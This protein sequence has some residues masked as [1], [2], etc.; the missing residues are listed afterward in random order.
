MTTV[1]DPHGVKWFSKNAIE[2]LCKR[3]FERGDQFPLC[4]YPQVSNGQEGCGEHHETEDQFFTRIS[5][6]NKDYLPMLQALEFLP[7][8]PTLFNMGT[9]SGG[10]LS[11]CFKFDIDD[12]MFDSPSGIMPTAM[13]AAKVLKSGGGVG[14]VFSNLRPKGAVVNSTHGQA[15]GAEGVARILHVLAKEITQGGKRDAAQMGIIHCNH[16][17]A[18]DFIHW[19]DNDPDA[20]GTFNISVALTDEFMTEAVA[21][22]NDPDGKMGPQGQFLTEMAHSAW[23]TGDPGCYFIDTAERGNPTP[24]AGLLTGSN[25]CGEVPLLNN[26][27]CNLGSINLG[28]FYQ[29]YITDGKIDVHQ[30][31]NWKRLEQVARVATRYLDD[32][33][34]RNT[35]PDPDIH[36]AAI[37]TR[38][39]GL[40]VCGFADLLALMNIDY[41]SDEAVELGE[42]IMYFIN[43]HSKMESIALAQEKGPAPCFADKVVFNTKTD[44]VTLD[45]KYSIRNATRTCIAPTGTIAI[46]MNASSG[47]EPYFALE[48]TRTMGDGTTFVEK[49][50]TLENRDPWAALPK[51]ANE[52]SYEWH[53][54]HQAAFQKHTDLA[55]SKTINMAESATPDDILQAYILMWKLGCKGGTVYR[56]KSR[57]NQVLKHID[58]QYEE[59]QVDGFTL[60]YPADIK[61]GIDYPVHLPSVSVAN[62]TNGWRDGLGDEAPGLRHKFEVGGMEGYVHVGLYPD[63]QPAELFLDVSRQGSMVSGMMDWV[64][65]VTSLAFQMAHK[66]GTP[67]TKITEKWLGRKFE[68]SGF[69]GNPA[70][71]RVESLADYLARWLHLKFA[72]Q[73]QLLET[74]R[75]DTCP[76]CGNHT[77]IHEGGCEHCTSCGFERC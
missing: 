7:N 70:I 15:L 13:K 65:Q 9:K 4:K 49:P 72:Q 41:E 67:F 52:V 47:I 75:Q 45:E 32:V 20:L 27:P 44:I 17:D 1:Y 18:K 11:A 51:T 53:V 46:L 24:W 2:I 16:P 5:M 73:G 33:L 8:S 66:D 38:K 59:A 25:P 60:Q 76:D 6:G 62:R 37:Y 39:L 43:M 29:G 64:G 3:Y 55:V 35:F 12:T 69:T 48:N 71:P 40:G 34:D 28:K 68:P 19:K 30:S 74:T 23:K 63:G 36:A 21:Q 22:L 61:I 26:E 54:K 56:D 77:L 14:Y 42:K 57:L 58:S 31:V 50:W 10:T